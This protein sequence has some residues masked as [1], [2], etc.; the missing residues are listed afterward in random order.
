[1]ELFAWRRSGTEGRY[2]G[3][4]RGLRFSF[5]AATM[6]RRPARRP[7]PPEL[8]V[9]RAIKER[10]DPLNILNPDL[11]LRDVCDECIA[12]HRNSRMNLD[13][14]DNTLARRAANPAAGIDHDLFLR[15]V[16]C[17]LCT[18]S[19]P[20]FS[21]LGD[22]NDG[23]RGRIQLMRTVADGGGGLTDRVRRHL[24]VCLDCRACETACPSGVRVRP[25]D[26]ALPP[27]DEAGRSAAGAEVRLVPR[28]HP[29]PTLPLRR[30]HAAAARPGA[31]CT[32][33]R[34]FR[35]GRAN[36]PVEADSRPAGPDGSVV[37]AAGEAGAAAAAFSAGRRPQAGPGGVFRRL[38][39]RRDV[40]PH[41][42]G[43]AA[44]LAAERLRRL[45]S[46]RTRL[47]RGD[48][49]PRRRQPRRPPH[50]R[51]QPGRLR[52]RPLRRD[53]RQSRRLRGDDEGV[54]PAL[55]R[56]LAAAPR[57]VRRRR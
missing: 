17:G 48:P 1:M 49:F 29:L 33:A 43:D 55:A 26:R 4:G 5:T 27:G 2:S 10:F 45:R 30:P 24:E 8:R 52:A 44:R 18:S 32:A 54:R 13:D 23:P 35:A 47:L 40:P 56:R 12:S 41:A 11:C 15:C 34:A 19:C 51:R 7:F 16:H 53:R 42:L 6:S 22:E 31:A 21:E 50:G 36:G 9:M 20:T 28:D 39:G 3:G 57:E 14:F 25:A 46:A 37:A 38:R